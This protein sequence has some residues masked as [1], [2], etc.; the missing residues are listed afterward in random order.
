MSVVE[1]APLWAIMS[2]DQKRVKLFWDDWT[3]AL[4]QA[5]SDPERL[6][7]LLNIPRVLT[8]SIGPWYNPTE[9]MRKLAKLIAVEYN[10]VRYRQRLHI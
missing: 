10:F 2:E 4:K 1:L 3:D 5:T 9:K 6:E 8:L 7:N